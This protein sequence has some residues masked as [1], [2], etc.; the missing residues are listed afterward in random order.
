MKLVRFAAFA[1]LLAGVSTAAFAQ[2]LP[3]EKAFGAR[4]AVTSASLSPDGKTMSFIAP[5]AQHGNALFTVP[6]D[7]SAQ[8]TRALVATGDP[9]RLAGCSWVAND[10]LVCNVF[11][12]REESSSP[13][14]AA[15][16]GLPA[17]GNIPATMSAPA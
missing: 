8:P 12:L 16:F 17:L 13:T 11:T 7:G 5:T 3:P 9:E 1:T 15:P 14:A 10:R 6:V 4:E 2:Q